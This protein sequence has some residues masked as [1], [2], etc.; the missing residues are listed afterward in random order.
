MINSQNDKVLELEAEIET[1]R[2][3]EKELK[4][5]LQEKQ[6]LFDELQRKYDDLSNMS[7]W[8]FR[9]WKKGFKS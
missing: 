6:T 5:K 7:M 1:L 8:E 9:K 2:A 3:T 4:D